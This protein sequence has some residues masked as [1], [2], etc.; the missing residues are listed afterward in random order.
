METV[1][2][3]LSFAAPDRPGERVTIDA[4]YVEARIGE[5]ARNTDLSRY[6]L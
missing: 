6:I 4:P 1:L 5:I 2:E 3:D